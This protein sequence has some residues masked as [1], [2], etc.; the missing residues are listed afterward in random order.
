[1]T[2]V[3]TEQ[4]LRV[5]L[6]QAHAGREAERDQRLRAEQRATQ[7]RVLQFEMAQRLIPKELDDLWKST[8]VNVM[9]DDQFMRWM[10]SQLQAQLFEYRVLRSGRVADQLAQLQKALHDRDETLRRYEAQV[11][12]Q[13]QQARE[14]IA[15]KDRVGQ[16]QGEM[17]QMAHEKEE[18][19][20]DLTTSRAMVQQ[21]RSQ[22]APSSDMRDNPEAAVA[23]SST[24]MASDWYQTWLAET[25]P[26]NVE[27]QKVALQLV[28]RGAAFFRCEIVERLNAQGLLNEVS[29]DKPTGTGAR[30]FTDLLNLD[31]IAEINAGYGAAVPKPLQLTERGR[32]AYRLLFAEALEESA[33][34][35]LLKRHK[36]IEHTTL[37]LLAHNL[38]QRFGFQ[39]IELYPAPLHTATGAVVD[40]DLVAVSPAGERLIIE[41][42]RMAMRRQTSERDAKWSHL[43]EVTHGQLNVVVFG[44][45]QQSDLMTELSEWINA[46]HTKKVSLAVCQ[47]LKAI[48]PEA[49]SMWTYTTTWAI[50]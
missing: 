14:I 32:E 4:L 40:P 35:R 3:H 17:A 39:A 19:L 8:D 18:V 38:L 28:G 22:T 43:A 47:Y 36:T 29:P 33:F 49:S 15:L 11:T 26:E 1:M 31:F 10:I 21:L 6:S 12:E 45:R 27:R 13:D 50:P 9:P 24:P 2:N 23:S 34:E 46:T 7:A 16:L 20:A 5:L 42:E 48:K 30:L 25:T 44:S 41:C 37:N